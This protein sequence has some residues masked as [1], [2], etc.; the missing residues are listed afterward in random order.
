MDFVSGLPRTQKGHDAIRVIVDRL[1]KSAHFLPINMKYS[2]EKL[3]QLYIDEIV[4]LHGIPVSIVSDRDR[5]GKKGLDPTAIPWI[6]DAYEKVKVIHQ[7]L[8]TAQ[9]RQKSYADNR[10]KDLEFEV[11]DKILLKKYHPDSTHVLKPEEIDIDESLTYEE[12]LVRILDRKA[13]ELR[14]KQI[15]LVKVLWRK[16]EVEEATWEAEE[17]IRAK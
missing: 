7:K 12:R 13:K 11:G 15:P 1:T 4:R 6:E 5:R 17:D 10:R 2:L 14:T 3:A 8:Q 9:S 16:H